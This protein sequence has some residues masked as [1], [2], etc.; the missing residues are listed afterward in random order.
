[1]N[2]RPIASVDF[3]VIHCS[4]TKASA[5]IG[6]KEIDR[7]H[8]EK[9]WLEI[10]YHF[11]IRRDGTR[12]LGRPEDKPGAHARGFNERSLGICMVGGVDDKLKPEANF[13]TAQFRELA[14][15]VSELK[16]KYPKAKVL[17]HRDLPDVNKACPS[18]DA[19]N[20][21]A[22]GMPDQV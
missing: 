16:A 1:M 22:T 7:W 19:P 8:R 21:Y 17:G 18:F 13:T 20:W 10:G 3:I 2:Y 14:K 6:R 4:A 9:G 11:V 15:L 5:D 12:E